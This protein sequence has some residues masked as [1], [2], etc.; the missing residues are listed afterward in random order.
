MVQIIFRNKHGAGVY[1]SLCEGGCDVIT[2]WPDPACQGCLEYRAH[3]LGYLVQGQE[4]WLTKSYYR[5]MVVLSIRE[6]VVIAWCCAILQ[7]CL[8]KRGIVKEEVSLTRVFIHA[9][10]V[11]SVSARF[12]LHSYYLAVFR[13][14]GK[15]STTQQ[16]K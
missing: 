10:G 1:Y 2:G 16:N 15:Y 5:R 8:V 6:F 7:C 4:M 3:S 9:R 14:L 11:G 12:L 13:I